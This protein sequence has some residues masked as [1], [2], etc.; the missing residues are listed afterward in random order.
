MGQKPGDLPD[1]LLLKFLRVKGVGGRDRSFL[2]CCELISVSREVTMG[3]E[4]RFSALCM[5]LHAPTSSLLVRP[6]YCFYLV[7][8]YWPPVVQDQLLRAASRHQPLH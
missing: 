6:L 4:R 3:V 2:T 8:C 1:E 5:V 7:S